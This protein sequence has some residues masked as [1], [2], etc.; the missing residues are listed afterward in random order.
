MNDE[1]ICPI[2]SRPYIRCWAEFDNAQSALNEVKC[3]CERCMAWGKKLEP[4]ENIESHVIWID[5]C[6]LIP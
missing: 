1:K 2:M 6:R 5:G 4:R 3:I